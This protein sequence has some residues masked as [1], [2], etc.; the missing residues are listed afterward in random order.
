N[1]HGGEDHGDRGGNH[2]GPGDRGGRPGGAPSDSL[3]T[4]FA[5]IANDAAPNAFGTGG[6]FTAGCELL[7]KVGK[8]SAEERAAQTLLV[9]RLNLCSGAVCDSLP[10]PCGDDNDGMEVLTLGD[11]ADSLDVLLCDG[12]NSGDIEHLV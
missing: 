5:C 8:R 6:C 1:G 7:Q 2:P 3:D 4:L 12:G 9:T 11:V 10:I